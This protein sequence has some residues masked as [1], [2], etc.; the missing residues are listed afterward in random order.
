MLATFYRKIS[1]ASGSLDKVGTQVVEGGESG[2]DDGDKINILLFVFGC[3]QVVTSGIMVTFWCI[4]FAKLVIKKKWEEL[5][6]T[7]KKIMLDKKME[8]ESNLK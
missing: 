3:I 1:N 5:V 7:N 2:T 4:I 8:E 6:R